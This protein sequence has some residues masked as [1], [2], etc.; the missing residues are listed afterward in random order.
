MLAGLI[1]AAQWLLRK[2]LSP[3]WRYG[4]WLLLVVRLLMPVSP[5]SAFSI[6]NLA[7]STPKPPVKVTA[8]FAPGLDR[9]R[10]ACSRLELS[11]AQAPFFAEPQRAA[12]AVPAA[13]AAKASAKMDWFALAFCGWLAGVC[14]FGARL[15]W[16][17]A[18]FRS[19]IARYQPVAD[20]KVTRLFHD[21]RAAFQITQPVRLIESEEVESP[22]VYGLGR[23]W[24]LLPDGVFDRFS[25]GELR[26]I[27]LH[28]LA[29]VKRRDIEVN[30]LAA[31]LQILHW[32]NPVLW[33]AFARMRADRELATDALA[34][35]HV[36]RTENVRYG[37]TILKVVENLARGAV[38]PGLV[39]IAEGKA[40]LKERLRAIARSGAARPWRWAA[41]GTAALVAAVGLTTA[42]QSHP[43]GASGNKPTAATST[44]SALAGA[45][46]RN[47]HL[48]ISDFNA[49]TP[50]GDVTVSVTLDYFGG[51]SIQKEAR[52]DGNGRA[53]IPYA[54]T[55]LKRLAYV[56]QKT[57]YITLEGEWMDQE[58][59]LLADEFPVKLGQGAEIGG[60]VV[61]ET[62]KPVANAEVSFDQG[63]RLLM[64]GSHYRTDHAE[65][66][67]V[68]TGQHVAV[69]GPDGTWKAK[70]IWPDFQWASLRIHHPDFADLPFA[71]DTTSAMQAEGKGVKVSF[72][73]LTNRAVR[74]T[75]TKGL[76]VKGRVINETGAPL[77]GIK[78]SYAELLTSPHARDQLLGQRAVITDAAGKFQLDHVPPKH[79]F[80]MVQ[81]PGYGPA[82][83]ELDP[84]APGSVVE[85]RLAKGI[86]VIGAVKDDSDN[87]VANARVAFADY[88]IW[89]GIHWET[90]TD[91]NGRFLW[92]DAPAEVFQLQIEKDGFLVQHET[93]DAGD[94]K[95]LAIRLLHTLHISGKVLDAETKEPVKEFHIDWLSRSDP[96]DF[97]TGYP[98]AT[99]PA[100]NGVYSLDLGRL[101]SENWF[102]GYAH[103]CIFRVE[104]DGY[105]TFIS[106]VFSS[107]TGDVGEVSPYDIELQRT[108]QIFG[109]VVD[110]GRPAGAGRPG[111]P[112]DARLEVVL[113]GQ[114]GIL[115][116]RPG[117][118]LPTNRRPGP[119]PSQLQSRGPGPHR[120]SR[121]GFRRDRNQ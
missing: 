52:T 80:F 85:L 20:E 41:V 15:V 44:N 13:A 34:L 102:G 26:H 106:R 71:T 87:P 38:Q 103:V 92:N 29:H 105:A 82:V 89:R 19:R 116:F 96:R 18:R 6:F 120:R 57:N 119:V 3:S 59:S 76:A 45:N 50:L 73:D 110:A 16:T 111:R 60:T 2:R 30:W 117:R 81:T 69:T 43:T 104:A 5:H 84:A 9:G 109:T 39:G 8:G 51:K 107:R 17:N 23:K 70:C 33:L 88:G 61:D 72:A 14:F 121:R 62:G 65:L 49:A 53:A 32:F 54:A 115:C 47:F 75:L 55:D 25:T 56:A 27:F 118:H 74:L 7:R 113:V 91:A 100:S 1:L 37:E 114:T 112:Q 93:V 108:P 48:R 67:V 35:A 66:W 77:P 94:G 83:A 40:G 86:K 79:L 21:C 22:A 31:L 78:V 101:Y 64:S 63:M 99:I 90:V 42:R 11:R 95:E 97:A 4:L 28:E 36:A 58:L 98:F 24:L 10:R 46:Q 12:L 68:P